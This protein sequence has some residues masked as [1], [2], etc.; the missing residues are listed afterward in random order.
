MQD[1]ERKT[2]AGRLARASTRVAGFRLN[3]LAAFLGVL[4]AAGGLFGLFA[5]LDLLPGMRWGIPR[6]V[7]ACPAAGFVR[8]PSVSS[9][10]RGWA[11][12]SGGS[13]VTSSTPT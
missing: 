1:F 7:V 6:V 13:S 9:R 3:L 4:F 2:L 11:A 10:S 8:S 5:A 12:A